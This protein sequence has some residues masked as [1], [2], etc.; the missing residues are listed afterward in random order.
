MAWLFLLCL[1]V[2]FVMSVGLT[3]GVRRW[4]MRRGFI[5][6]PDVGHKQHR[7]PVALG[8][9]IAIWAGFAAPM[10]AA[11]LMAW[12]LK[13][14]GVPAWM[15]SLVEI[16]LDGVLSKAPMAVAILVGATILHAVGLADDAR[17]LT[18]WLKLA[19][20]TAVALALVLGWGLRAAVLLGPI[21]SVV[22]TVV[23]I[24]GVTNAFNLMD[25]MD[26]LAGGVACLAGAIFA[27]SAVRTGQIF[28][29]AMTCMLI[30]ATAGFLI[31]NVS[32]ASIFMGDSGSLV[33]GYLLAVMT[34]LTTF[35]EPTGASRPYGML[36][37]VVVLAVPL[38]DT[39]SVVWLRWRSGSP[40]MTGDRRH[41]SHRLVRRGMGERSAVLTIYLATLA[42]GL[43]A[44]L[45]SRAD[46]TD[47]VLV[48]VQC[49]AIVMMIAIL[50]QAP[51]H[52]ASS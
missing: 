6:R 23:W 52:G 14:G 5:D 46:W 34:V 26:G 15:P 40:I 2:P 28:V 35:V 42:T 30:G 24:V 8:G 49:A 7:G 9:G 13:T 37:P 11:L 22:I 3:A 39:A 10:A 21:P 31:Y 36:A 32:P 27:V 43:S 1:A 38:Y 51:D 25:N 19:V 50:E 12:W 48:A 44:T 20:M 18:P 47:A 17:P 33:V 41:F 45:L 4:A 29:P 16:H